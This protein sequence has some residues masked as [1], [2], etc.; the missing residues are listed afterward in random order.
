MRAGIYRLASVWPRA[1]LAAS[2]ALARRR[3]STRHCAGGLFVASLAPLALASCGAGRTAHVASHAL[4]LTLQEYRILPQAASV[5][6][7]SLRIMA[8]NRGTLPHNV[9]LQRGTLDSNERT[10]LADVPILLPGRC[11]STLTQPLAPGRYL[12]ASTVGNQAVLGMAA[13]LVVR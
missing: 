9:A 5:P 12:L 2:L 3:K 7:G 6:A 11:G 8:C 1:L 4:T 10:T 13:T